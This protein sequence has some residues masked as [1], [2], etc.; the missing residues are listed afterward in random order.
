MLSKMRHFALIFIINL[1]VCLP[2]QSQVDA[3]SWIDKDQPHVKIKVWDDKIYRIGFFTIDA[4]FAD[5]GVFL[6]TVPL[7]QYAL[8]NM[9]RQVPVHIFDQNLNNR[10]DPQDYIEFVGRKAT[11]EIDAPLFKK[12]EFQRHQLTNFTG[13]TNYYFITIRKTGSNLRYTD[14]KSTV[15]TDTLKYHLYEYVY[16]PE[17]YY[18]EGEFVQVGDKATYFSEYMNGEGYYSDLFSASSNPGEIR[19]SVTLPSD[20]YFAAGPKPV[21]ESGIIGTTMFRSPSI[22]NNQIAWRI[23]PDPGTHRQ[24][25]DTLFNALRPVKKTFTLEPSDIGAANT[26]LL[27]NPSL[28]TGIT[29]SNWAHSHTIFRYPK[30]NNMSDSSFAHFYLDSSGKSRIMPWTRYANGLRKN[31]IF[32]DDINGVRFTGSANV[33][34]RNMTVVVPPLKKQGRIMMMD[35]D[36]VEIISADRCQPVKKID[37]SKH[38]NSPNNVATEYILISHPGLQS[39]KQEI[40]QYAAFWS[41]MYAVQT[42]MI[43]DLYDYFAYGFTHPIAVRNYSKYLIE[44]STGPKPQYLCLLGRGFDML[45]N[46]GVYRSQLLPHIKRNYIP[47]MGHPVSDWM[48]TSGLDGTKTEPAIATGRVTADVPSDISNYLDKLKEYVSADNQY[49]I[50]QKQVLH[51]GGGSNTDQTTVI[52][53]RM[54]LLKNYVVKDP[55]AGVVSLFTKSAIGTTASDFTDQIVNRI[56]SGVSLVTFLGHGSTNVTDIDIGKPEGYLNRGKYPI[57]YFNGCQVGNSAIPLPV[58]SGG[59][60]ERIFKLPSKAGIA[61]IGQTSLSELFTV[62][63]QMEAFYKVYFDSSR[64]KTLG[65]VLKNAIKNWQDTNSG[66]NIIHNRQLMLQGDPAV[67]VYSPAVPDFSVTNQDV[68]ITPENAYALMDSFSVAVIVK[69]S[70]LGVSDSFNIRVLWTYPDGVTKR[71]IYKRVKLTGYLDTIF[72]RVYAKDRSVEG[73]NTFQVFLNEEKQPV[74]FTYINNSA[75]YKRDIPGNGVNLISPANFAIIGTDSVEL[76]AQGG[77]LFKES[78]DYYFELDTT[79]WFNSPVLISLEKQVKPMNRAILARFKTRLPILKD[80]Q[81]YFWRARL[82]TSVKDGGSWQMRSF[83]YI[84]GHSNGWMQNIHWQYVLP[85]SRNKA[86][87]V[88]SDSASRTLGF[89]RRAKKIYIDCQFFNASN[90]GVKESGFASQDLNYGVCKNGLVCMPWD[91]KKLERKPVDPSQMYPDCTWGARWQSLGHFEDYQLY[92]AFNMSSPAEQQEFVRFINLLP[93]SFYVTIYCRNQSFADQWSKDVLNALH[94]IGSDIFDDSSYRTSDAMWVCLGQKGATPGAAQEEHTFGSVSPYVAMEGT[95]YGAG[96][97]GV[98]ISENIGPTPQFEQLYYRPVLS[99]PGAEENDKFTMSVNTI[100]TAGKETEIYSEEGV[101]NLSLYHIDSR[102]Y[103]YIYLKAILS[104]NKGNTSPNLTNWRVTMYPSPEGSIYPDPRIGYVFHNDTLYEGDTFN[105]V[106]PFKNISR[107][108]FTD[109]I[110]VEYTISHKIDR[111]ILETGK[112]MM[113]PLAPDSFIVFRKR[114][115]T[116]GLKGQYMLQ[117][118]FNPK[119]RQPEMT[120]VNNTAIMNFFVQKDVINPMLD[121]TFDGRRILNGEIVSAN[122]F[123]LISSKDENKFLLQTDTQKIEVFLKKPGSSDFQPVP[124]ESYTYFPATGKDNKARV[125]FRPQNLSDGVYTLK[126]QSADYS[127]NKA[128]KNEYEV[129]FEIVREQS[130]T[131]F[132]PYPNP[133]TGSM[134][135]VFTLTGT[136]IPED[137]RVKIM[138][139]E[140]RVVKEVSNE[141]LGILRVGNNITDWTWDG[142]DQFGDKLANGTYF[143]KVTVKDGGEEVKLRQTKGDGSFKE[144]VGVIYLMR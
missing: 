90:K 119:F 77:N 140:G 60:S 10:L 123:I 104:D 115:P 135:F 61:F 20:G 71:N 18:F 113:T 99:S 132:Y 6:S 35:A 103:R 92:Y 133:T 2:V 128:G 93:D 39:P 41:R 59:L 73:S 101:N 116:T 122:P 76:I 14:F 7:D 75:I 56:N 130:V 21:L 117:I 62:S 138:N 17:R 51:L 48:Y 8:F 127:N 134:R 65:Y 42:N 11:G 33:I 19:Y 79:P 5:A 124:K 57:F 88:A 15:A 91:P 29:Y 38:L 141:E 118:A 3:N 50:W 108:N 13:D 144:Q 1:F 32:Y 67:P 25:G 102:K 100:D 126:V 95:M 137:I 31:P 136:K 58:G 27:F 24:I 105:L 72:L 78:E 111:T 82:S 70:G 85:A 12:P 129:N 143:F 87:G 26:Y 121:V 55:F 94:K 80:T 68:F 54:E 40:E 52:R 109:S 46:K 69:N 49:Q 16:A 125:E 74:E 112:L 110:A 4:F 34:N 106:L 47:A 86:D 22:K 107:L 96:N 97:S 43:T 89:T 131:N 63:R 66:L 64:N 37:Y 30:V 45:Y 23:G 114:F 120:M 83:T 53:G 28:P 81:V 142:T 9:G 84:S 98:F 44:K 139:T 36:I